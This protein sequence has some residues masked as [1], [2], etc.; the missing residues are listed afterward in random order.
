MRFKSGMNSAIYEGD[1]TPMIDMTFQLIAFF[2]LLLNFSQVEQNE[3]IQLPESELAKPA[4]AP[5]DY[6]IT[7]QLTK[8][9]TVIIGGQEIPPG[10][11]RPYLLKERQLLQSEGRPM[12]EATVII[13]AHKDAATGVVQD[14]IERCQREGLEK[15]ALRAKEDMKD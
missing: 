13:R 9:G 6:P 14:L 2:A 1:F 11:L 7:L 3:R 15:F 4:E 12:A 5:L 10:A 8:E